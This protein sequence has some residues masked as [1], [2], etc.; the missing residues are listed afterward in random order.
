MYTEKNWL[1]FVK[2]IKIDELCF[3]LDNYSP[4]YWRFDKLVILAIVFHLVSIFRS[5]E[6]P[7]AGI[8]EETGFEMFGFLYL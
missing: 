5:R 3:S 6:T 7:C 2:I 4:I 8:C 1:G